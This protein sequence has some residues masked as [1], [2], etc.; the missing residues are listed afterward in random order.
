MFQ[1]NQRQTSRVPS[2]GKISQFI[3]ASDSL[4]AQ[5]KQKVVQLQRDSQQMQQ[6]GLHLQGEIKKLKDERQEFITK[7]RKERMP[8]EEFTS[9]M[10]ALYDKERGVQRKLITIEQ[11]KDDFMKLDLE[12]Q[13]KKY[14]AELQSEMAELIHA[15]P[16][17]P[18]ER[19]QVFMLKKRIVNTVW[20]EAGINENREIHVKFRTNFLLHER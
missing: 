17:T 6:E 8:D 15:N 16:Q 9:Q 14:E 7:A 4:L 13:V 18:E 19:H 2:L 1:D 10:S 11:A 20:E 12:E 3:I 5:A